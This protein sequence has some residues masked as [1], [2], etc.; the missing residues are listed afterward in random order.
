DPVQIR[1]QRNGTNAANL[2]DHL[3]APG[4]GQI[5]SAEGNDLT[6][7]QD[8]RAEKVRG[9]VDV[10]CADKTEVFS[11]AYLLVGGVRVRRFHKARREQ[12][13]QPI[14]ARQFQHA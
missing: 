4:D 7:V 3:R 11:Q 12:R 1:R 10:D 5:G 13:Q 2:L 6:A 9:F 8:L 14:L